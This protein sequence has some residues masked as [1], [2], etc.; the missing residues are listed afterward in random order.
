MA[1]CSF[2]GL[3]E[4]ARRATEVSR[5]KPPPPLPRV[6]PDRGPLRRQDRPQGWTLA[7][8]ET[9]HPVV[10]RFRS[11]FRPTHRL[12]RW[13]RLRSSL[14][15]RGAH[16]TLSKLHRQAPVQALLHPHPTPAQP[17]SNIAAPN[18]ID[19]HVEERVV[20]PDY[21]IRYQGKIYQIGR[22]RPPRNPAR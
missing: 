5:Q 11:R 9:F 22:T 16:V 15:L 19:L 8:I 3:T 1:A 14:A 4:G 21:T 2:G 6:P 20:T 7:Q 13:G 12:W 18:L 10:R 17:R